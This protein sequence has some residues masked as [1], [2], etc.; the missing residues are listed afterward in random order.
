MIVVQNGEAVAQ[1]QIDDFIAVEDG[2][3]VQTDIYMHPVDAATFEAWLQ[4]QNGRR[5]PSDAETTPI[6]LVGLGGVRLIAMGVI[7]M[8]DMAGQQS[9][10]PY[11]PLPLST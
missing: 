8:L 3:D 1:G 9:T 5:L 2:R 6:I 7:G 4:Q 11:G 10:T